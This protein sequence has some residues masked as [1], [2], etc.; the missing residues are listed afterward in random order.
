M[1]TTELGDLLSAVRQVVREEL[2]KAKAKPELTML[3]YGEALK[4]LPFGLTKLKQ[5]VAAGVI[6]VSKVGG[7]NYIPVAEIERLSTPT[8]QT[9][10]RR[11]SSFRTPKPKTKRNRVE[12]ELAKLDAIQ[13]AR[14]KARR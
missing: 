6:G 11:A 10:A 13:K 1:A 12:E 2:T 3:T 8:F 4:R 9:S 7:T 5:L 14:R